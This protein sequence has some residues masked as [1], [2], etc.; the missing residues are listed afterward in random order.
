MMGAMFQ[1][2]KNSQ[3]Y[4]R[5]LNLASALRQLPG[6]PQLDPVE[7]RMLNALAA[8]WQTG[9]QVTVMA[10]LNTVSEI[11]PA[12]AHRRLKALRKSGMVMFQQDEVDGRVKYVLPTDTTQSYFGQLG[13]CLNKAKAG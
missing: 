3:I 1:I 9:A 13:D 6:F 8:V 2:N 10:A 11:S 12:T 7:E 5:F 4:T